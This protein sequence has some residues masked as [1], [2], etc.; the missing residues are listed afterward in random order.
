MHRLPLYHLAL[1]IPWCITPDALEAMLVI[2]AR[3][4]MDTAEIAQR[5]HGSRAPEA[6]AFRENS[7]RD[8]SRRMRMRDGVALIAIDGPIFRYAD[9]FTDMSGGVTTDAIAKDFQRA[10]D[11]P[12]V[13]AVLLVIDSPGGEA[14]GISELA[15]M[16]YANRA[17]K[18]I[19]AYGEGMVASAAC[20]LASATEVIGVEATTWV[21]SIG[22]VI[23]VPD[24]TKRP[25]STIQFV[26][27]DA[28]KKR[29]DPTTEAG[30]TY[31]Q[32]L[33]N[34][35]NTVFVESIMRHR[36]MTREAVVAIEG[37]MLVGSDAVEA[38]LVDRLASEEE[39][40]VLL[41]ERAQQRQERAFAP[42]PLATAANTSAANGRKTLMADPKRFWSGFF[43]AAREE[44]LLDDQTPP[45]AP[46]APAVPAP[47]QQ[48]AELERLRQQLR[49]SHTAQATTFV[50][51][52]VTA[53]QALPAEREALHALYVQACADDLA[54]GP[55][56]QANGTQTSR[57][58]L[59]KTSQQGRATHSLTKE[60]V[61]VGQNAQILANLQ[62]TPTDDEVDIE[63]TK[64][65]ASAYATR[66]NGKPKS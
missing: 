36:G 15:D 28:P 5:M 9:M 32:G 45:A 19:G 49:D 34:R 30:R 44:G 29:P 18:P 27:T 8:D 33:A 55:I 57:A 62:Q 41:R 24:P 43:G 7:R 61:P 14:T 38:G 51:Q 58:A 26:S 6:L 10:M 66:M 54:H 12:G 31:I 47:P 50:E 48:S 2:A 42:L 16:I 64:A 63:A 46:A 25:S 11:D 3:E 53:N 1:T 22:T 35:T 52:L 21:G 40:I 20:W 13:L 17:T 39:M 4:E 65:E 60:Q 23:G 37:G 56:T 59:V